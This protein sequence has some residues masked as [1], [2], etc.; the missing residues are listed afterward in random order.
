MK[1]IIDRLP[2]VLLLFISSLIILLQAACSF[3]DS[4]TSLFDDPVTIE[5]IG[6]EN[7][8]PASWTFRPKTDLVLT[9]YQ[10]SFSDVDSSGQA[11][12]SAEVSHTFQEPGVYS[13]RL[14]YVQ[15][16]GE[17]GYAETQVI[18]R[19]G[20]ISGRLLAA[21]D[22]LVDIDT[23][24][25]KSSGDNNTFEKAQIIS[26][27][28]QLSG[29]VDDRDLVDIFQVQL[30]KNQRLMIQM[31]DDLNLPSEESNKTDKKDPLYNR[32]KL[33]L[34]TKDNT[35][36]TVNIVETSA[37]TG[38]FSASLLVP[39]DGAYYL[40]VTAI[41]ADGASTIVN[42]T[43][44]GDAELSSHGIYSLIIGPVS[45]SSSSEF[46]LGEVNI[47][48]K[49]NRQYTAQGLRTKTDLG[50]FK[51]LTLED[52]RSL[53]GSANIRYAS[54]GQAFS[55]QQQQQRWEVLQAVEILSQ[56]EDVEIAEPN[57]KRYPLASPAVND[58][59][60]S[61]QWHY[62][63]INL[64]QA[65]QALDTSRGDG[66]V[67]AVL[68]TGILI[69]HPDL[70]NNLMGGYDF[71]DNDTDAND[72]GDKSINGQRSSFHGT[73]V[74]G[75]IA[76]S[77]NSIG[78][79]GIAPEVKI[80]PVRVLGEG[81]GFSSD[82]IAGVCFAAK[83][84]ASAQAGCDNAEV[85]AKAADIINL[86]LGGPGYS[87]IEQNVYSSVMDKGIIVI[88]AAG[89][90]S[91][92]EPFYPATYDR[93]ISV[94]ALSQSLEQASYSNFGSTI[95]VAAPGGDFSKDSGIMSTLGDDSTGT[96]EFTYGSLQGTSMAAPH[97]AGVAV[98]M[99][100]VKPSLTHAE[101]LGY[102]NAGNLTQDL[103]VSGRD[104][105]FGHG[106]INAE[107]AVLAVQGPAVDKLIS[108]N[109]QL[110]FNIGVNALSFVLTAT[111][112]LKEE[113]AG[114]LSVK[115]V[116]YADNQNVSWLSLAT[117]AWGENTV[118]VDRTE[119]VEGRHQADIVINSTTLGDLTIRVTLQVGNPAIS[120][121]AG[122]QY[123][124][125]IDAD[126]KPDANG[127]LPTVAGSAPLVA[128]KGE[129]IYQITE[130]KKGRYL[131]STGSDLDFD[132]VICD[133]GESC[134]QYPTLEQ[135]KI[136]TISEE[137]P[138]LEV[139]MS[140]NYSFG[141][142]LNQGFSFKDS[143]DQ[144][145]PVPISRV[146]TSKVVINKET[147]ADNQVPLKLKQK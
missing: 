64:P 21:A 19:G 71:V 28:A 37:Q 83:L 32:V 118:T 23:L 20:V 117:V 12:Q 31:A 114:V 43:E 105:A 141:S 14:D 68:D 116:K 124:L 61:S 29:I 1:F 15:N 45:A 49:L 81:G 57:W 143:A 106:L 144:V 62:D 123:V 47:L 34:Y 38:R 101:F 94:S 18:V 36:Q 96:T 25:P 56:H 113:D 133:P 85:A 16:N 87:Q 119:L 44:R 82:I 54:A 46:V 3:D 88:A 92:S 50:R 128:N 89:N 33:T 51:T 69:G 75:I 93:V 77:A 104:D 110:F 2:R 60:Y 108:S 30:Q 6:S 126:A 48:L 122:V 103:G 65:W 9:S 78:G 84:Q 138:Y 4:G 41:E 67:V 140:V 8:A 147:E 73:H 63:T 58:P 112:D 142:A 40:E 115:S 134:G 70:S 98:L 91:T 86:S 130:I 137:Q 79:V 26:S 90:E 127:I 131:V 10:W 5:S 129:Y 95:D 52:A 59:L 35:D 66:F 17:L 39:E 139:N 11:N 132:N 76:A 136:I 111:N 22:N 80:M 99:K 109:N 135:P 120:A 42:N 102:L 53:M 13:V 7:L 145:A 72:P 125:L 27:K 100:S 24:E 146:V 74:A 97:V 107:K 121:N 55:N